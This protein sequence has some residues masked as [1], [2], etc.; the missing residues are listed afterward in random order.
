MEPQKSVHPLARKR[1]EV[2]PRRA[3]L[4]DS[5]PALSFSTACTVIENDQNMFLDGLA[6]LAG[7]AD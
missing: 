1:G 3:M 6:G 4:L 7:A 5:I 2:K